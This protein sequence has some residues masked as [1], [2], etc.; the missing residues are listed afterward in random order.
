MGTGVVWMMFRGVHRVLFGLLAVRGRAVGVFAVVIAGAAV[1]LAVL[2]GGAVAAPGPAQLVLSPSPFGFGPVTTGQSGSQNFVLKN[3]GSGQPTSALKVTVSGSSAF[4]ITSDGCSG[5][6]LRAGESCTV[7]V[8]FAPGSTGDAAAT[9]TA[10]PTRKGGPP[11]PVTDAL[12]GTGVA[13]IG[14]IYWAVESQS[15]SS[16]RVG[17]LTG[18]TSGTNVVFPILPPWGVAVDA[19]NLYWTA[20]SFGSGGTINTAPLTG[21]SATT[22][23]SGQNQPHGVAVDATHIYWPNSGDRTINEAPLTGGTAT[24]LFSN[25]GFAEGVAIG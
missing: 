8:Q 22:L 12:S 20:D 21:G 13:P 4:T 5:T 2:A 6:N 10:A 19:T 9:L 18:G 14:H 3:V 7:T 11:L 1:V 16:I 25:A 15:S 24:T 17:P 23:V